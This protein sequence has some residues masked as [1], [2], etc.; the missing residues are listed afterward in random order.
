M[1]VGIVAQYLNSRNDIRD[2]IRSLNARVPVTVF[3]RKSDWA[4]HK[5]LPGINATEIR[6]VVPQSIWNNL[7]R[8]LFMSFGRIPAS[9]TN[10]FFVEYGKLKRSNLTRR[11]KWERG[12]SLFLSKYIPSFL[13]YDQYLSNL[14][15]KADT[16]LKEVDCLILFTEVYD[17]LFLA[18]LIN[19]G[20]PLFVYVYSWDH[21]CKMKTFSNKVNGYLVWNEG[22][23][24]DLVKLHGIDPSKIQVFGS[25]QLAYIE[26]YKR[27]PE[28]SEDRA[29]PFTYVYFGCAFG[30]ADLAP[31]EVRYIEEVAKA[32]Q[33][34]FPDVKLVIRPY[35]FL[36]FWQTYES[37]KQY[38]NVVFDDTYRKSA[39]D[40]SIEKGKI[41]DKFHK[42]KD[43]A[44]FIH[45]GTTL[46]LEA[47][48]FDVPVLHLDFDLK[49]DNY[50]KQYMHQYHLDKYLILDQ[51]PNIVQREEELVRK[52]QLAL[53]RDK[54][55]LEYGQFIS[56]RNE[57]KSFDQLSEYLLKQV[58]SQNKKQ[59][60]SI[61]F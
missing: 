35:P 42:I 15:Y 23:K 34:N 28:Y 9:R 13:S 61:D 38:N 49:R 54:S 21:A 43:A 20:K 46:G 6:S 19:S 47:A 10:Y 30:H 31:Y 12:I 41:F 36:E 56:G 4:L 16:D 25:T 39:N 11:A 40:L 53:N 22:I 58:Q 51:F 18:H 2:F 7:W 60:E 17:D 48:Y 29:F 50:L 33:L 24:E 45:L 1:R 37:L 55:Y 57:V 26:E 32:L 8:Y 14:K 52:L 5:L 3:L 27:S 44:V 59:K